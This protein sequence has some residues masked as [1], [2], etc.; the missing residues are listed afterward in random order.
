MAAIVADRDLFFGLLALQNGPIG[1][2]Q[3]VATLGA[4][5]R[6]KVRYARVLSWCDNE[7]AILLMQAVKIPEALAAFER[8]RRV[9]QRIADQH[10]GAAE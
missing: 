8:S 7:I 3:L 2:G 10:V 1:Q 5:T 4:W 6:A 9:K